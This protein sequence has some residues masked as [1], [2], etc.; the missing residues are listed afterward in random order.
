MIYIS[1]ILGRKISE[2]VSLAIVWEQH[3]KVQDFSGA[4]NKYLVYVFS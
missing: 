3:F 4:I 2:E 1:E